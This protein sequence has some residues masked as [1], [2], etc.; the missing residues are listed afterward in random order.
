MATTYELHLISVR[1]SH[2]ERH[3]D[4]VRPRLL[5][6][7]ATEL[8]AHDAGRAHLRAYPDAWLQVQDSDARSDARDVI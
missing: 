1:P 6:T 2:D 5:G 8:E 3:V 4:P 7:Y